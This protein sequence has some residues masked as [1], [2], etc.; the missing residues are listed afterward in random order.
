MPKLELRRRRLLR[1]DTG[2]ALPE[3]CEELVD[4]AAL[5]EDCPAL[6]VEEIS[7]II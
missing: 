3:E 5:G 7:W 2:V 6:D 4:G 1:E